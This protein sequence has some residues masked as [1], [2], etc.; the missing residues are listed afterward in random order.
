[1]KGNVKKIAPQ[2]VDQDG[3]LTDSGI[4]LAVEARLLNK[5]HKLPKEI[6]T[7]LE[8]CAS[9]QMRV[10]DFHQFMKDE[11]IEVASPHPFL[12]RKP[13]QSTVKSIVSS[14]YFV[15]RVAAVVLLLITGYWMLFNNTNATT[16]SGETTPIAFSSPF[17]KNN[18]DVKFNAWEMDAEKGKVFKLKNG[19]NIH[20][21]ASAFVDKYGRPVKGKVK[22]KYREFH[23]AADII[24]SGIPMHYDS[25]GTRYHFES[26]GMFE[27][28]GNQKGEPV[29]LA[30]NKAID[31]NLVSYNKDKNFNHYY[32]DEGTPRPQGMF[33]KAQII[34]D[35][36][37]IK[38]QQTK[39]PQ[40]KLL[41]QAKAKPIAPAADQQTKGQPVAEV[42]TP[43]LVER[44]K[45]KQKERFSDGTPRTNNQDKSEKR[46]LSESSGNENPLNTQKESIA[47]TSGDY[48]KLQFALDY[49]PELKRFQSVK[50]DFVSNGDQYNPQ[51]EANRWVLKE[52]W[53][54][55]TL[56]KL[57]F[58]FKTLKEHRSPVKRAEYS[59]N[60][61]YLLT[62]GADNT[63]NLFD[64]QGK[65][66][67]SFTQVKFAQLS[68]SGR[69][70]LLVKGQQL[71]LWT[72]E[73]LTVK[74]FPQNN[75][76]KMAVLSDNE[77]YIITTTR[78]EV[79]RMIDLTG[80][81]IK[82]FK[83]D[84]KYASFSPNG[85]YLATISDRDFSLKIWTSEG[86][87]LHQ[88][89][90]E[91]NTVVFSADGSHL[92]T[93]S[94]RNAAQLWFFEKS[95]FNTMLM[96]SFNHL[97]KVNTA[98][99]SNDGQFVLTASN[100]GSAKLWAVSG[101]R[102]KTFKIE[103][104]K[105]VNDAVF[106]Q[107]DQMILT[108]GSNGTAKIWNTKT[109]ALM[110]TLRGHEKS[111]NG[112][113]FSPDQ[114]GILT[115]SDDN[116]VMIWDRSL[117]S[118]EVYAM[119]LSNIGPR[120]EQLFEE[121]KLKFYKKEIKRRPVRKRLKKFFTIIK[122]YE[123]PIAQK[124][125]LKAPSRQLANLNKQYTSE[126][127]V[128]KAQKDKIAK[129]RDKIYKEEQAVRKQEAQ[130]MHNFRVTRMGVCNIDRIRRLLKEDTPITFAAEVDLGNHYTFYTRFYQITG[131]QNTAI[132]Q[133]DPQDLSRFAFSP[134]Q[135]NQLVVILPKNKVAV[136]TPEQFKKID[137][138]K[139]QK[140]RQYLFDL[141][142]V[143]TVKSKEEF[144]RLLG[145]AP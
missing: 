8:E 136:F 1:M 129:Q 75:E 124:D 16:Q 103:K 27:I 128:I 117:N 71:Q 41:G 66:L 93:S 13:I 35:L 26:G 76:V 17:D 130:W 143:H 46:V 115:Y 86:K 119:D 104:Y 90:G 30:D 51:A 36:P 3:H 87:Y 22:I 114:Q 85:E 131:V 62:H 54:K 84:F 72:L 49:E 122:L 88:L 48:F 118:E 144:D 34:P 116:T 95:N 89:K 4:S 73:G 25:A 139:L 52:P 12:D 24:A 97:A 23:N 33:N 81:E 138:E 92:L 28:R 59:P 100:D 43:I 137:L 78:E 18:I 67:K 15:G 133:Y 123:S 60:G 134:K 105:W 112:A 29:Y 141:T 40:W 102:L 50:W 106:S 58:G 91:Y 132:V 140:D 108:A 111:L 7:H 55:I 44:T 101:Q 57:P 145:V 125:S 77:K 107:D 47:T 64:R 37:F 19:S 70:L 69:Y 99:F 109:G 39:Q 121:A 98:R 11:A 63:T 9:C 120:Y 5:M 74:T 65:L 80:K 20:V 142:K 45:E 83:E 56:T 126:V 31:V 61:K 2:F 14:K 38:T 42:K 32:L 82:E 96:T 94:D 53:H 127:E 135:D 79:S 21:P 6:K 110:H 10:V 68:K 113:V